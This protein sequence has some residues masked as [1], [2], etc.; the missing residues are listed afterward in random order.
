ML[1]K[2][3]TNV[4][5]LVLVCLLLLFSSY[6]TIIDENKDLYEAN[7]NTTQLEADAENPYT[8]I[9]RKIQFTCEKYGLGSDAIIDNNTT[10]NKYQVMEK[11]AWVS[12]EKTLLHLPQWSLLYCWIRKAAS[13]SWNK[14]F[15]DLV[16]H[17]MK[18]D[19]P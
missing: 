15:F 3:N 16:K 19:N 13:T 7:L 14:I 6:L 2:L 10:H 18:E 5:R 4:V 1:V 12:P 17:K 9:N 8:K 11:N